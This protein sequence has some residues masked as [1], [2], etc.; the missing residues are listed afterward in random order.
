M[1]VTNQKPS[2]CGG[3]T[4]QKP[5]TK[6]QKNITQ[7]KHSRKKKINKLWQTNILT[8]FTHPVSSRSESA[9][10]QS[11]TVRDSFWV[12]R[13]YVGPQ[14]PFS[15]VMKLGF[16]HPRKTERKTVGMSSVWSRLGCLQKPGRTGRLTILFSDI[17][18]PSRLTVVKKRRFDPTSRRIRKIHLK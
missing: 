11:G 8:V 14:L 13:D 16:R 5:K 1:A 2:L 12:L 17:D 10:V 6:N 4:N 15:P 7:E 18:L 3:I 9:I